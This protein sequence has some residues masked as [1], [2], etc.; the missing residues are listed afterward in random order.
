MFEYL[1]KNE[2]DRSLDYEYYLTRVVTP[3]LHRV[4]FSVI[5]L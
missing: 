1:F 5:S 4:F 2:S 3:P